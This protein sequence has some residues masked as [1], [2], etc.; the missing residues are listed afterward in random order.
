MGATEGATTFDGGLGN[1]TYTGQGAGNTLDFSDVSA[2]GA[3]P[4]TFD[5]TH[6]PS[7]LATLANVPEPFSGITNLI[8]LPGGNTTFVGGSTGGY[9]FT[10]NGSGNQTTFSAE[11]PSTT[12]TV[13]V[14]SVQSTTS[15][16]T[17]GT[18]TFSLPGGPVLCSSVPVSDQRGNRHGELFHVVVALRIRPGRHHLQPAGG[19][20]LERLRLRPG[21]HGVGAAR[22]SSHQC[23]QRLHPR[24]A[25]V[26]RDAEP[27][28]CHGEYRQRT[29]P[30]R[31]RHPHVQHRR[32]AV[33]LHRHRSRADRPAPSRWVQRRVPCRTFD[34]LAVYDPAT[35]AVSGSVASPV[36]SVTVTSPAPSVQ[37]VQHHLCDFAGGRSCAGDHAARLRLGDGRRADGLRRLRRLQRRR[38]Q[39]L[40][41]GVVYGHRPH[42]VRLLL[43]VDPRCHRRQRPAD[44]GHFHARVAAGE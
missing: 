1:F 16:L 20:G 22:P 35:N 43:A 5:V 32:R 19:G 8:G 25:P 3:T 18:V 38:G 17:G 7:P 13:S 6:T 26:L 15:P 41:F 23:H 28:V 10:G 44:R 29:H 34:V 39:S 36:T 24:P 40:V 21:R 37:D 12:L 9:T 27:A 31:R 4:L 14:T 11:G 33:A 30:Y 2:A 42:H